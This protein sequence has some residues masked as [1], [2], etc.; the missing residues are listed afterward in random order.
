MR[1][2]K[3]LIRLG[4]CPGWSES[5][6]SAQSLRWFCHEAAFIWVTSTVKQT[7]WIF[8][9][10]YCNDPKFLDRQALTNSADPDQTV[11]RGAVWSGSTLFAIT[12]ASFG[13]NYSLV[14][15]NCFNF[16]IITAIFSGVWMFRSFTVNDFYSSSWKYMLW[17]L[18]RIA[19]A[20]IEAI[21]MS[22]H[23]ICFFMEKYVK[24][25][26]SNKLSS[27]IHHICFSP[28]LIRVFAVRIMK[29]RVLSCPLSA[30]WRPW[31]D[32]ADTQ[33]DLSLHWAHS[34]FVGFVMRRLIYYVIAM[35]CVDGLSGCFRLPMGKTYHIVS[36]ENQ[37]LNSYIFFLLKSI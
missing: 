1:T 13:P 20:V 37:V 32:W 31:S 25:S 8:D 15:Q 2:A 17:V 12:S 30:Q 18:I 24:L 14:K 7:R 9:E 26:L 33:A 34:H 3:T 27:N 6:L 35:L 36:K 23:N 11:P 29:D 4:G 10:I 19:S 28:S 21:L 16:R 22:T 5:S